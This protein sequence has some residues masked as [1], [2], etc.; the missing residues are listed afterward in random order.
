VTASTAWTAPAPAVPHARPRSGVNAPSLLRTIVGEYMFSAGGWTWTQTLVRALELFDVN[1]AT[2]R[3]AL[4]RSVDEGW[5]ERHQDGRRARWRLTASGRRTTIDAHERVYSFRSGR[6]DWNG[7]WL[8]LVVMTSDERTRNLARRRLAWAGFGWLSP[9]LAIS[10]HVEREAEAARILEQLELDT[11]AISFR[12]THG[13]IG[14]S[15]HVITGAWDLD[16]LAGRYTGFVSDIE[17]RQ[18]R[19]DADVFVAHTHL[20]HEWRRFVY[21]D[22]GLPIEFLPDRWIGTTAQQVFDRYYTRWRPRASGW[23]EQVNAASD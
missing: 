14:L 2:A 19:S 23:F 12:A 7:Q 22:P 8:F 6:A 20:V 4:V 16:D 15:K 17:G 18:P 10:P 1:E 13:S 9:G 3:R 11:D 5:L 21:L